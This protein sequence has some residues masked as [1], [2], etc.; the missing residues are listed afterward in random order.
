M[1]TSVVR[2]IILCLLVKPAAA[3]N[4]VTAKQSA[5]YTG[6]AKTIFNP[7][8]TGVTVNDA[9]FSGDSQQIGTYAATGA[10][11]DGLPRS[12][13][14]MS[15]GKVVNVQQGRNPDWSFAGSG[16]DDLTNELKRIGLTGNAAFTTDAAVLVVDVTVSKAVDIDIAY[17]FGSNEYD[18]GIVIQYADVF[19]LFQG[20]TN[21][22]LIGNDPVSVLTMNCGS[23][24]KRNCDQFIGNPS[25]RVG[26]SLPGY[27][28]TQIAT[29]KLPVGTNQKVKIA[30]ADASGYFNDAAVFLGFLRFQL[31]PTR[32]PTQKPTHS[33]T[34]EPTRTPTQ[35]PTQSPTGKPT[36]K[37]VMK[38]TQKPLPLVAPSP[39]PVKGKMKMMGM[40]GEM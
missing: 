11:F 9:K 33:P 30:I 22:A 14:V 35:S 29:L 38:M 19:G 24:P 23:T 18:P 39:P 40:M 16:D 5:D 36:R 15:S 7:D 2:L 37:P 6:L 12:G 20:G 32:S 8:V 28:K 25:P 13:V 17:I 34:M 21:I 4:G 1:T 26:T 31:A 3:Q 10:F 27:T